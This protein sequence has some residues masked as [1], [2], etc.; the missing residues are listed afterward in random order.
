MQ[1][2]G[3]MLPDSGLTESAPYISTKR[4]W[5]SSPVT[6]PLRHPKGVP[7]LMPMTGSNPSESSMPPACCPI[8]PSRNRHHTFPRSGNG[9]RVRSP[10]GQ[11]TPKGCLFLC[12]CLARTHQNAACRA[13]Q[14][15]RFTGY[16]K[17][18]VCLLSIYR[19]F[20]RYS[21]IYPGSH[22]HFES[23][24]R[25]RLSAKPKSLLVW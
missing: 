23:H 21:S 20:L 6:G 12:Q 17:Q 25:K 8:P 4:K 22:S 18:T 11:G 2:A 9:N 1:H 10:H 13:L 5:Q 14:R 3:G 16:L 19:D 7:F 24:D 15:Y